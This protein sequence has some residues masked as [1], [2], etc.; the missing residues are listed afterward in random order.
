MSWI[1]LDIDLS[2]IDSVYWEI[3]KRHASCHIMT[4]SVNGVSII[5]VFTSW[6]IYVP[7]GCRHPFIRYCQPSLRK[8]TATCS[9]PHPENECQQSVDDVYPRIL[10]NLRSDWLQRTIYQT[11]AALTRKTHSDMRTAA[12]WDWA[13]TEHQW[14]QASH[15]G[16]FM[17]WLAVDIHSS[18]IACLY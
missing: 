4:V 1:I 3:L 2:D 6:V 16:Y 13:S 14:Y 8:T 10:V 5:F 15:P 18:D 12:S 11:K 7:I 9:L 17:F